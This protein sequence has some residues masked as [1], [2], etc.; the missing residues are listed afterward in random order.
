VNFPRCPTIVSNRK[1]HIIRCRREAG[2]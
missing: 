1:L 2:A